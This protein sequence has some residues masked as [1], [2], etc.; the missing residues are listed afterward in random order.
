M[1]PLGGELTSR[2]SREVSGKLDVKGKDARLEE[3]TRKGQTR[4][5][6]GQAGA[7][8]F[9]SLDCGRHCQVGGV[10]WAPASPGAPLGPSLLLH[11]HT[12]LVYVL[13]CPL[14][15]SPLM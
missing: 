8:A 10:A 4:E 5:P 12:D 7:E 13:A 6:R 3:E 14:L 15:V 1:C 9:F 11:M 2:N